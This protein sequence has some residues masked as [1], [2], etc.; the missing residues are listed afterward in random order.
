MRTAPFLSRDPFYKSIFG[1]VEEGAVLRLRVLL[2]SDGYVTGIVAVFNKDGAEEKKIELL[3]EGVTYD[4]GFHARVCE[5]SL[6]KGLYFYHFIM[7]TVEGER[8]LLNMGGG[9]GDFDPNGGMPWQLTVYKK[10]FETPDH[11]KGGIIYQIFPDRFY[12]AENHL[13]YPK[14]RYIR[15][16]WGAQPIFTQTDPIKKLGND[17]FCGNLKG[18][19][20]KLDYIKG[21]GV[22]IIYLNPIFEAHSNHRYNTADYMK[23]DPLLGSEEDFKSLCSAAKKKG[24]DV[25]LDGVFSHTGDDSIY[26]NALNRYD[27]TGAAN[28]TSSP[29][30]SWYSFEEY[31]TKY[32][33]WWGIKTLPE[34][35]ENDPEFSKFI[36]GEEGVI[37]YWMRKGAAGFR[38]DVADE[39][40]DE[41]L[42]KVRAA[43][44][45]ESPEGYLLGEVWEDATNKISY[46]ARRKFLIGDQLD[47]VMNYPFANAI[48]N[49]IKNGNGNR[50]AES[51]LEI[52]ENY[53]SPA[54][55]C[56]MNH[57]GTHD[58][59]RA[60]TLL[61]GEDANGR[62]REWQSKEQLSQEQYS[63]G[64]KRLKMAA[65]LQYTLPGI[66]SLYYGD[67]AG[68]SGYGDPFCRGCF[69]WGNQ[70]KDLTSFYKKLGSARRKCSAFSKGD[71]FFLA[72]T[73]DLVLYRRDFNGK[74]AVMGV[75]L[76]QNA[77][78]IKTDIDFSPFTTVFGDSPKEGIV[79]LP[80]MGYVMYTIK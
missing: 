19:E 77:Q 28:S 35:K 69:P 17:Y 72:A 54:L 3:E 71:I 46:S 5:V 63:L 78:A 18:I 53:P 36:T 7:Y 62:G 39:L 23:I 76:S 68:L 48:I 14:D 41:F 49:F 65:L 10:G 32:E 57:I 38:L 33:S 4:G 15:E 13:P 29:Y 21:L 79:T 9:R 12:K 34:V 24:I 11:I 25:I 70:N 58:T 75:N 55:H 20:E 40:P 45:A 66:P 22:S 26:F 50:F 64:V 16:D 43:V 37:R 42:E 6:S 31:P 67:E 56:L 51:I 30:Y 1:S 73:D 47:S 44:K 59:P 2:P 61:G 52:A 8:L 74:T 80:P 60:I 27:S